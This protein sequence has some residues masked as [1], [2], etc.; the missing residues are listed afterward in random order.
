MRKEIVSI[1][2]LTVIILAVG[3]KQDVPTLYNQTDGIYFNTTT[4]SL[5]Y[6]FAKY[7]NRTVD[8]IKIPVMVLGSPANT[9]REITLENVSGSDLSAKE[10]IHFKL[11]SPY[12]MPANKVSTLLPVVIYRTADLDSIKA[13]FA[14]QLKPN[15]SFTSGISSKMSVK[16]KLGFLQKPATWGEINGLQWAGYATNL[17]TWTKTKYKLVLEALYDPVSDTTVSEFPYG[18]SQPPA[19]YLQ[20]LQIVKNYIRTKYP[21]NYSTPLGV[22]VTLR[23]PDANNAVI[24]VGPANY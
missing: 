23:D 1:L 9:D 7:P 3:C 18:R 22:G 10:G 13:A 11:L 4:D 14:I 8:T 16:V 15:T 20:Y 12:K 6:T 17:G 19:I 2:V 21:G 5:Q 24:Q